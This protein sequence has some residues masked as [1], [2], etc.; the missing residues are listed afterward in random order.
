[1]S[2]KKWK[3]LLKMKK[4]SSKKN[5]K[6]KSSQATENLKNW[7]FPNAMESFLVPKEAVTSV[8]VSTNNELDIDVD[9]YINEYYGS[10]SDNEISNSCYMNEENEDYDIT[11][12]TKERDLSSSQSFAQSKSARVSQ[13]LTNV[14]ENYKNRQESTSA[15]SEDH[16]LNN[17]KTDTQ[18]VTTSDIDTNDIDLFFNSIAATVKKLCPYNQVVAKTTV[19]SMVSQLEMAEMSGTSKFLSPTPSSPIASSQSSHNTLIA[20]PLP[21][22]VL[23]NVH[24][25]VSLSSEIQSLRRST[26]QS[27][28]SEYY[29][30]FLRSL[31]N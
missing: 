21:S 24:T 7:K 14:R 4:K 3:K 9:K 19:F 29:Q 13:K 16:V 28:T 17:K 15:T 2:K 12:Q 23:Q 20:T 1:M 11:L 18:Q 22:P 8:N 30:R 5:K 25:S 31:Q 10:D 6:T 26:R 27:V